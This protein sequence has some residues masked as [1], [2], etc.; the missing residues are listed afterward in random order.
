MIYLVLFEIDSLP[1]EPVRAFTSKMSAW[2]FQE[3]LVE[4]DST[5]DDV[6]DNEQAEAQWKALH[7]AGPKFSLADSWT[8]C[9]VP[10][11]DE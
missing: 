1:S 6:D 3:R 4:Y 8:V 11:D 10:L 7:P 2:A 5:Y 9:A